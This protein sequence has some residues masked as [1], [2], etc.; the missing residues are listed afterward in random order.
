[1]VGCRGEGGHTEKKRKIDRAE[2]L[3]TKMKM[4][5]YTKQ[6]LENDGSKSRIATKIFFFS[7]FFRLQQRIIC[8][9]LGIVICVNG[10]QSRRRRIIVCV[11]TMVAAA[12][13][14]V[15]YRYI[16]PSRM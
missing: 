15:M 6:Q 9:C 7:F 5:K 1:M 4:A 2:V 11:C 10:S 16:W 13:A 8:V 14:A 12:L 3:R